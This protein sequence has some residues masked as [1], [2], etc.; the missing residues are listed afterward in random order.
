MF[1]LSMCQPGIVTLM[2]GAQVWDEDRDAGAFIPRFAR[3]CPD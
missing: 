1:Q 2:H 3:C